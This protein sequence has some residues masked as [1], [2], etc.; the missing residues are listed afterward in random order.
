MSEEEAF[1]AAVAEFE[2]WLWQTYGGW[3]VSVE[4]PKKPEPTMQHVA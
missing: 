2:R 4:P 1:R 3:I